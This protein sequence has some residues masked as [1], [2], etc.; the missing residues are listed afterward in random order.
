MKN[1][2]MLGVAAVLFSGSVM[3]EAWEFDGEAKVKN[4]VVKPMKFEVVER[5]AS[6]TFDEND[7]KSYVIDYESYAFQ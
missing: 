3:A 2:M 4:E 7:A 5:N 6:W 1:I